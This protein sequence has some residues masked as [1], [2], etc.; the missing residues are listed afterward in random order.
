MDKRQ[1]LLKK[2]Y[3]AHCKLVD[4]YHNSPQDNSALLEFC[5]LFISF[6]QAL[7]PKLNNKRFEYLF[8]PIPSLKTK[9]VV[10]THVWAASE[11]AKTLVN[12][13]SVNKD[14]NLRNET[15]G[16]VFDFV[17]ILDAVQEVYQIP[18]GTFYGSRT[19]KLD[20]YAAFKVSEQIFWG[21]QVIQRNNSLNGFTIFGLRQSLELAGK[22]IIGLKNILERNSTIC[23][24]GTQLPWEFITLNQNFFSFPFDPFEMQKIFQWANQFVHTGQDSL[25]YVTALA[26]ITVKKLYAKNQFTDWKGDKYFQSANEII[27]YSRL[28]ECFDEFLREKYTGKIR[29]A[30]WLDTPTL[31]TVKSQ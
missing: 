21:P 22:E 24:H 25:C 11:Y 29:T 4:V 8:R 20:S 13:I 15:P 26:L 12:R 5:C 1:E 9:V 3:T 30:E 19:M 17:M 2:L 28:K 23:I 31:A 14:L 27:H 10:N 7:N 18:F 6:T 16:V